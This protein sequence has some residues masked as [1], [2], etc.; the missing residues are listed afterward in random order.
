MAAPGSR[1]YEFKATWETG[2]PD[3]GGRNI[4]VVVW[5]GSMILLFAVLALERANLFELSLSI[6]E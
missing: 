2:S 1:E 4:C 6:D 3:T 5:R